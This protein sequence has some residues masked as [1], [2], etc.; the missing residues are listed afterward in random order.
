[1]NAPT[2]SLKGLDLRAEIDRLRKERNAVILAHYYQAPELQDIA[3]FV[4]IPQVEVPD[5]AVYLVTDPQRGDEMANWSPEEALPA[6][7]AAGRSPMTIRR[8]TWRVPN[9][10][11]A[12][13]TLPVI[14]GAHPHVVQGPRSRGRGSFG[15]AWA[16]CPDGRAR[17]TAAT[18]MVTATPR[19]IRT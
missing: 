15:R 14:A 13:R 2:A 5:A 1:M 11:V 17:G 12:H 3:D 7:L 10:P 8:S 16:P 19:P 9:P 6:I 4:A 18:E